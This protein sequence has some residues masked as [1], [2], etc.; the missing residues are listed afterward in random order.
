[1][2]SWFLPDFLQFVYLQKIWICLSMGK[3][4]FL[5]FWHWFPV[6]HMSNHIIH[7]VMSLRYTSY[8]FIVSSYIL[9]IHL[10]A[11]SIIYDSDTSGTNLDW[12][13]NYLEMLIFMST[14][15]LKKKTF[16]PLHMQIFLAHIFFKSFL[17]R[18]PPL[19]PPSQESS[20]LVKTLGTMP[21]HTLRKTGFFVVVCACVSV[22]VC[23]CH[24]CVNVSVCQCVFVYLQTAI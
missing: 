22:C 3:S 21:R 14:L 15:T 5:V 18:S 13:S 23:V 6:S 11:W 7:F 24:L 8:T 10:Y 12:L 1:M 20:C 17:L 16:T 19:T 2:C 4:C 9:L